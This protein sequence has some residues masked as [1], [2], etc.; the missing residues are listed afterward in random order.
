MAKHFCFIFLKLSNNKVLLCTELF[1]IIYNTEETK[2]QAG[3]DGAI[4]FMI[5]SLNQKDLQSQWSW[6]LMQVGRALCP[7]N[8]REKPLSQ[9]GDNVGPQSR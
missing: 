1:N 9:R 5:I 4:F 6:L 7:Q 3:G 8:A 2:I